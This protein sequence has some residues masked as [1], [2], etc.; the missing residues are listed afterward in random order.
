MRL[1]GTAV[2]MLLVKSINYGALTEH[3]LYYSKTADFFMQ[4]KQSPN[5]KHLP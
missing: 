2:I 4:K 1:E 3:R 5:S